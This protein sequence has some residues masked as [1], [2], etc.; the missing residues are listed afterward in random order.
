M[1]KI[2]VIVLCLVLALSFCA[3]GAKMNDGEA[4]NMYAAEDYALKEETGSVSMQSLA[5]S[6]SGATADGKDSA[7]GQN[8]KII[9][10]V[11]L[12]AQTK[13]YTAYISGIK[14][15][16]S[17]L[18]GYV[19]SS[20][21][22]LGS[23][24]KYNRNAELVLRIPA[25]KLDEFLSKAGEKGSITSITEQQKNVTLEYVDL[26]S[27]ISAF[28][29]ERDTLTKLLEEAAS[30]ENVLAIQERLSEVNYEI[31]N[32]TAQL[33]V[34]ENRVGYSTVTMHIWEVER[35]TEEKPSLWTQIKNRF[36][37]NLDDMAD[38]LRNLVIDV[39]GGIPVILPVAAIGVVAIIIIRK[40]WKKRK[41]RKM[42]NN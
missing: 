11:E 30:L 13:E 27:R 21:T 7:A 42:N 19:E 2:T 33:R 3:C 5:D 12:H 14:T 26:E 24:S 31:E 8:E 36:S 17:A 38:M 41:A 28:R 4:M 18:G 16:V 22:D 20:S 37:D 34:L 32:Y 29:T 1:K 10:T 15:S 40:L 35:V 25:D 9:K 6:A 23:G 39:V